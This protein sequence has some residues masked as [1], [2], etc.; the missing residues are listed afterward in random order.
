MPRA[1]TC[2]LNRQNT[3]VQRALDLREDARR[4]PAPKLDF[5]CIDCGMSVRPHK[6]GGGAEAHFEHLERNPNCPLS[7]PGRS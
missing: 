2:V 5:R 3:T 1:T 4:H 6:D 7:D